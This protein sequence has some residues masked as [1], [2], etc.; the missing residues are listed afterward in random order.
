MRRVIGLLV[1]GGLAAT[2]C[3]SSSSDTSASE[4]SDAAYESPLYDFLGIDTGSGDPDAQQAKYEEQERQVNE[5]VAECMSA[6]G[7]EWK[8]DSHESVSFAVEPTDGLEW[9][10]KE[11]VAKYGFGISTQAFQQSARA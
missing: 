4:S 5:M 3:G 1:V 8:P 7:F 2:G 9:G 11:W 6:E 10:T